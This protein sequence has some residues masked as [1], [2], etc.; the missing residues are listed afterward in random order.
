MTD[1][2]I[3]LHVLMDG[4]HTAM[5]EG[6]VRK[7]RLLYDADPGAV[8]LS[9]SMP[10]VRRRWRHEAVHSWVAALFPDD[11]RVVAR[12]RAQFSV[13]DHDPMTLLPFV[14]EDVA[15]AAQFVRE[16]RIEDVTRRQGDVVPVSEP[17]IGRLLEAAR[18]GPLVPSGL[19]AN[20][21][22]DVARGRF[23]LAGAQAK[24]ALQ[25]RSD[26]WVLPGGTEPSTHI[27]KLPI[28]D[29]AHQAL[30][31]VLTM[32]A[33]HRLGLSVA[34]T[35]LADFDGR[36]TIVVERYDRQLVDGR[37]H[38]VHQEDLGQ[39]AGLDPMFKYED[40]GGLGVAACADLV[41]RHAGPADVERF[42]E[43]VIFNHLV[44]ATDAHARNYSLV[45]TADG[46]RL[47]PLYDLNSGLPYGEG[48][49]R[50][51]AMRIGGEDR[52]EEIGAYHWRCFATDVGLD[53]SWVRDRL[54]A[55]SSRL[56][57]AFRDVSRDPDL[58]RD[59]ASV[60]SSVV[61]AAAGWC[62]VTSKSL[63]A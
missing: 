40:R 10:T 57:D 29:L 11:E 41:R 34:S 23:S 47:A 3:V 27:L 21:V 35:S 38:R 44:K 4:R 61:D 48:W 1:D 36:Q 55:M 5:L 15:G 20:S 42:A 32:R 28:P 9:V 14:G 19:D 60:A 2:R 22:S 49:A 6:T 62:A 16:E 7:V 43:A 8:P 53:Y 58:V 52:F 33:A 50:H 12:W 31:E 37:W 56:P 30:G 51:S 26:G 54:V 59:V 17:Q 39:A 13:R 25:R 63:G 45:V 46:A 18:G 24:I